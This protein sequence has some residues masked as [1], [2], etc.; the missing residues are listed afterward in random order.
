M[1][2]YRINLA[3]SDEDEG[4]VATIPEFPNPLLSVKLLKK[5]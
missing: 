1:F 2:Q 4:Y 5:H 3:W